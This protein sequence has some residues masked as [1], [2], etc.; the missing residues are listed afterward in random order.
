MV[1]IS[2][3]IPT[4][5]SH[6][7][8]AE[9]I[10]HLLSTIAQQTVTP[11]EICVSDHSTDDAV[12]T[13]T[14][15]FSRQHP[16]ISLK[17]QRN[18][19]QRGNSAANTNAAI[20]MCSGD[21]V[22]I[23]FQDDIF[24]TPHALAL[25]AK[26]FTNPETQWVALPNNQMSSDGRRFRG[27]RIPQWNPRMHEGVNTI[28]SPSVIAVRRSAIHNPAITFDEDLRMMMDCDYYCRLH[29]AFGPPTVPSAPPCV[30]NREHKG[31]MTQTLTETPAAKALIVDEIEICKRR[32]N[33]SMMQRP[34]PLQPPQ[35]PRPP[36]R[37]QQLPQPQP[38]SPPRGLCINLARRPD[39]WARFQR[40]QINPAMG[41][42]FTRT[43]R[44][45]AV[46]GAAITAPP[47]LT[48][49]EAGALGCTLSHT[50]A[51]RQLQSTSTD[52]NEL[53]MLVEDDLQI[54]NP[55]L[56]QKLAQSLPA[57]AA[58][59]DWMVFLLTASS[60]ITAPLP[61]HSPLARL[62]MVRI[63]R[64]A[65]TTGYIIRAR[66]V[67]ALLG[68]FEQSARG[69]SEGKP[70][71]VAA[72][73]VAWHPLQQQQPFV[74]F[75]GLLATQRAGH[76]DIEQRPVDYTPLFATKKPEMRRPA[77]TRLSPGRR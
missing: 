39:R 76:S 38:A 24:I 42:F 47:N 16:T 49:P 61:P 3:A 27:A 40:Q 50:S 14:Q 32:W 55:P 30:A 66:H 8:G 1:T 60:G 33:G 74:C 75:R 9:F 41:G 67:A 12:Q 68:A 63:T 37:P 25:T 51:L 23:M 64:A 22:K 17:W 70:R 31:Q 19:H 35:R 53:L 20:A 5:E 65:S 11:R 10:T 54:T 62:Q 7:R 34:R 48:K 28:S 21:V 45:E 6:G 4:W 2:I 18:P 71:A 72:L 56:L 29:Q 69:L 15:A 46:D 73:D 36:L 58:S 59:N 13:A 43:T 52:P 44:F 77:G 57:L 26:A